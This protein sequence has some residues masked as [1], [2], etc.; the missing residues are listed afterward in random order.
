MPTHIQQFI[1]TLGLL[2]LPVGT[3]LAQ[4][5]SDTDLGAIEVPRIQPS[6]CFGQSAIEEE[7]AWAVCEAMANNE[8]V[9]ARELSEQWLRD[10]PDSPAAHF[11][12]AE[13]LLEVEGNMPRTLYHLN[14]AE[15]L[16]G[17]ESQTEAY[18]SDAT[19]W[20]YLTLN[21]LAYVQQL[22]GDQRAA[23]DYL[24]K[25]NHIYDQDMEAFRSWPLIK[26]K[27]YDAAKESANRV[28]R[29]A[30]RISDR[31]RAWNALC[32]ASLASLTP[33]ESTNACYIAVDQ[34]DT[35]NTETGSTT[36]VD[37]ANA[38][39]V[40]L[41]LL[42][43]DRA[44]AY[45]DRA[46]AM[47]P[48]SIANPWIYKL[49]ITMNQSRFDEARNALDQMLI[50]RE[51]Q[52][53]IVNAMNRAEHYLVSADFLLL[54]GYAED[55]AQLTAAALSEPDR[56]GSYSADDKQ[57]E[58]YAALV[59]MIANNMR[60]QI[61]LEEAASEN[62]FTG[63]SARIAAWRYR[64]DAWQA[65][66][67]AAALFADFDILRNR[68]RPYAPLDVHIPEWVE[69]E[70][71]RLIGTGVVRNVL[72]QTLDAGAFQL[73]EG[74]YYA[75]LTEIAAVDGDRSL[76]LE[77]GAAALSLLPV[78]ESLLR[79]RLHARLAAAGWRQSD[80]ADAANTTNVTDNADTNDTSATATAITNMN[81]ATEHYIHALLLD[82][83]IMR[84]LGL[85]LPVRVTTDDSAFSRLA[86]S[87]LLRSPRFHRVT[88]AADG[89]WLDIT[90]QPN[91]SACLKTPNGQTLSCHTMAA[92]NNEDSRWNA[93]ALSRQF[94]T[95]TFSLGYE[96]SKAQRSILLGSN[97]VLSSQL[98]TQNKPQDNLLTQ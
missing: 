7:Q 65:K 30:T 6:S 31:A 62:L 37:L 78:Q 15:A 89:L 97:I 96:I 32:A 71:V 18:E 4:A 50:W 3:A 11:T 48:Y 85:S 76:T 2:L 54:A 20:H 1:L 38:S 41:S 74:Y 70:I 55:A 9:R 16:T 40:S 90:T 86:E 83:S 61:A 19:Q 81:T 14:Q 27:Q 52:R 44:E 56:N 73:N 17:Y 49:Y 35:P 29:S 36:I 94:Q 64:L 33:I 67:H 98:D 26:L 95:S 21:Q 91:L 43:I 59:N 47:T 46:T 69:P 53:P 63:L 12:L 22:M 23:L 45:L 87:Y 51:S 88:H 10:E 25:I 66:R 72:Q 92:D 28:L 24:D 84:R 75:W 82:P 39:E 5:D 13:I 79:A 93:Q 34:S 68:L 80:A 8:R 42:Q 57:K 77:A 60:Y 58:S